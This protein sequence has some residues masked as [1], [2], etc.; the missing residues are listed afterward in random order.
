MTMPPSK[1]LRRAATLLVARP[2]TNQHQTS[3]RFELLF[4]KRS[5]D[6][7]FMRSAHVWPGGVVEKTDA[8]QHW[9]HLCSRLAARN[10]H[11]GDFDFRVA[12]LRELFEE[13]G[14]LLGTDNNNKV[15]C[16]PVKNVEAQV[17]SCVV[18]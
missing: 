10:V 8:Q 7:K 14:L 5:P 18:K 9:P 15:H 4:V 3:N 2:I 12:A 11:L 1:A 6:A 13:T 17:R 16:F